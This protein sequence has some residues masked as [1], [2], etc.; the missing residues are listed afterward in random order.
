MIFRTDKL[1]LSIII[2]MHKL[3]FQ[4][5]FLIVILLLLQRPA[6]AQS[7]DVA[8]KWGDEYDV[9]AHHADLGIWGN[10]TD[11]YVQLSHRKGSSL[12]FQ[13]FSADLHLVS[14][15]EV[16]GDALPEGYRHEVILSSGGKD[17]W[18]FSTGD[19]G[20]D[21]VLY[22]QEISFKDMSLVGKPKEILKVKDHGPNYFIDEFGEQPWYRFSY[23]QSPDKSKLLIAYRKLPEVRGER[24]NH[25]RFGLQVFDNSLAKLGGA[26][27]RMPY[28][29]SM[30]EPRLFSVGNKGAVCLFAKVYTSESSALTIVNAVRTRGFRYESW[31]WSPGSTTLTKQPIRMD[32]YFISDARLATDRDGNDVLTGFYADKEGGAP[33]GVF[34][35]RIG[36]DSE[37][38]DDLRTMYKFPVDTLNLYRERIRQ[39][40]TAVNDDEEVTYI[41]GNAKSIR[42]ADIYNQLKTR[43]VELNDDGSLE[44]YG[45]VLEDMTIITTGGGRPS[46]YSTTHKCRDIWVAKIGADKKLA[47]FT[48]IPKYQ[49]GNLGYGS[50]SYKCV[51]HNGKSYLFYM[52]GQRENIFEDGNHGTLV[53]SVVDADGHTSKVTLDDMSND[54]MKINVRDYKEL[55]GN[56]VIVRGHG[57]H[58]SDRLSQVTLP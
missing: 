28:T 34:V 3:L 57:K 4:T 10:A 27:L 11:G 48:I 22:A 50:M 36:K 29:E 53:A 31:R 45:E 54:G 14:E 42:K 58:R 46:S 35:Q 26:E 2:F 12:S 17:Y 51:V 24:R 13:K 7:N 9:T 40:G 55:G 49:F 52:D 56:Q 6:S 43:K 47:W 30:M 16:D 20:E 19:R 23:Y 37:G 1:Y 5:S 41:I 32:G 39:A 33:A 25:D 18:F 8:F 15:K 21:V 44:L 38:G